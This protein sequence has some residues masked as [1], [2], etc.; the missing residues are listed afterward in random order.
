MFFQGITLLNDKVV[1][2]VKLC[3]CPPIGT[4]VMFSVVPYLDLDCLDVSKCSCAQVNFT[5]T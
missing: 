1:C 3:E 2:M 5:M 4:F